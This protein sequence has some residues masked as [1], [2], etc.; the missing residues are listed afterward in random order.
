MKQVIIKIISFCFFINFVPGYTQLNTGV[1]ARI[2]ILEDDN[3]VTI[4]AQIE[5]EQLFFRDELNYN[6]VALKRG[7]SG[8]FSSNSQSS[9]FTLEPQEKRTVSE[10]KLN[11]NKGEQ[12]RIYLFVKQRNILVARDSLIVSP[13]NED[14][15]QQKTINETEF[16]IKGIVI[17][18]VITKIGKDFHYFFYQEYMNSGSKYPFV[19]EIKEKPYFGRSSIITIEIE[20]RKVFEF[21]SRPDEEFLK[22]AASAALRD[23]NIYSKQRK[24]LFKNSR[25]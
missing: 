17:E 3:L 8:N 14:R 6:L 5:N 22:S 20:D 24:L 7:V 19:I 13:A 15:S 11:L 25:I 16:A 9:D 2:N 10:I 23:I 4:L 12:I 18:S 1:V 21:N